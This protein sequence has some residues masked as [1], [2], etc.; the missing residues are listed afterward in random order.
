LQQVLLAI[1]AFENV[2][3]DVDIALLREIVHRDRELNLEL[4]N[5]KREVFFR[6]SDRAAVQTYRPNVR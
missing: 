5:D 4:R 3:V 2:G 6:K 1:A